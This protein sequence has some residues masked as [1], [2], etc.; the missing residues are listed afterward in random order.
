MTIWAM[1]PLSPHSMVSEVSEAFFLQ[2]FIE[3]G[4]ISHLTKLEALREVVL[5]NLQSFWLGISMQRQEGIT[6][7]L[8]SKLVLI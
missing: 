4:N 3:K 7:S 8:V 6:I 5:Q 2:I 1:L